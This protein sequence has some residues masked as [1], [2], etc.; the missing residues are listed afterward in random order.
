M[1][2]VDLHCHLLPG[3][4]D[5]SFC[6]EETLDMARLALNSGVSVIA[7][8][9][10]SYGNGEM[11]IDFALKIRQRL[12]AVKRML[13]EQRIPLTVVSGMEI[14]AH[15]RMLDYLRE[16]L[17]L[18][19]NGTRYVLVE[20]A[21]DEHPRYVRQLLDKLLAEGYLPVV[22]HPE[23]YFFVQEQPE[24]VSEWLLA[25]VLVQTNKGSLLGRFGSQAKRCADYLLADGMV[26][27]IASDAHSS[28]YRTPHFGEISG[29]LTERY[30]AEL[31][32]RLLDS[33]PRAILC[34]RL[35]KP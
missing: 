4:D 28:K 27:V 26:Q 35:V 5:G 9:P 23:R 32:K 15:E 14:L 29:L 8:T 13:T 22:A 20:F 31:A 25:G 18:T 21:F 12:D 24:L 3:L 19:L 33:N 11:N 34:N 1:S 30:S 7:A 10:H 16:G 17:M 2:Y 6:M